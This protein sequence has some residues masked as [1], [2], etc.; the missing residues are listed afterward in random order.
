VNDTL[1]L[2]QSVTVSSIDGSSEISTKGA[3]LNMVAKMLPTNTTIPN[4][5]WSVSPTTYASIDSNGKLTAFANGKVT[6]T[7][8]AWDGTGIKGTMDINISYQNTGVSKK[9]LE[10]KITVYPNPAINGNFTI[11]GIESIKQIELVNLVGKRVAEFSNLNQP[12]LN[13]QVNIPKGI[14]ILNLFDDKQCV[15]KKVIIK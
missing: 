14:Y 12:F 15:S 8:T 1:T 6:V 10:D 4:I 3:S 13:V 11:K 2:P 7:A 5:T 9:F